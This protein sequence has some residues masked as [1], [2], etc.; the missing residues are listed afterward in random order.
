MKEGAMIAATKDDFTNRSIAQP[1]SQAARASEARKTSGRRRLVDPM[2]CE[3]DYS[4]SEREFMDAIQAYKTQNR[5]PFPTWSEVLEV[6]SS[7]GYTKN[8]EVA[9]LQAGQ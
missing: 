1:E 9:S 3:R 7:L 4:D 5:R 6:V 8:P 2:T